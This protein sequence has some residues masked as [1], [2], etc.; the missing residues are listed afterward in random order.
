VVEARTPPTASPGGR[1]R[2][3]QV[4]PVR[5]L[6]DVYD[7]HL[8][9]A[10]LAA[11][12]QIVDRGDQVM[13]VEVNVKDI[14]RSDEVARAI[15]GALGGAPYQVMDWFELNRGLFGGRRP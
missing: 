5:V 9:F 13:G 1:H 3:P 6:P 12:Q 10:S 8:A 7:E 2:W 14:D 15:E 11:G 4:T